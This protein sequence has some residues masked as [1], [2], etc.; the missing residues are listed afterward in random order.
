MLERRHAH[1]EGEGIF[2]YNKLI[3]RHEKVVNTFL[4]EED[5]KKMRVKQL[6]ELL[7]EYH[8]ECKGCAEKQ[9]FVSEVMALRA[10]KL[11]SEL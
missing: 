9:D 3:F 2:N 10:T 7:Q 8:K 1:K 4:Q 5:I 11:K 6:K